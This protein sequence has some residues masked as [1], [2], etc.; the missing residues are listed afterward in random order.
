MADLDGSEY[1]LPPLASAPFGTNFDGS[2]YELGKPP[3]DP[4]STFKMRG[5]DAGRSPGSDYI[6]WIFTGLT[7]DFAGTG[8]AGGTPTPIGAL[9]IDS[10]VKVVTLGQP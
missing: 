9:I 7:P 4:E 2:F 5:R 8:Y 1:T 6:I 3:L 10:V